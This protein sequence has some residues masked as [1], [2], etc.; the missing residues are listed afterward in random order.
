MRTIYLVSWVSKKKRDKH[1]AKDIY[2]SPWF[3]KAR[4]YVKQRLQHADRWF[5]LSAKHE[6]IRSLREP[7][8]STLINDERCLIFIDMFRLL[9]GEALWMSLG[10]EVRPPNG[11]AANPSGPASKEGPATPLPAPLRSAAGRE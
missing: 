5:I 3:K 6:L 8:R 1:L 2:D 7:G 10:R 11:S 9:R 4:V